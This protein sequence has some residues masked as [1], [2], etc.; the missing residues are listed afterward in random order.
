MTLTTVLVLASGTYA[1]RLAGP[2]LRDRLHLPERVERI[3]SHAA[4][5]LLAALVATAALT[6]D[7]GF[8]G[9]ARPLGV[10]VGA[11][12]AWRRLPFVA[13]VVLAASTTALL[14]LVGI[15]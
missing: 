11:L 5:A 6:A 1:L 14:R 9:W 15:P 13:V 4:T 8:S 2:L 7:G 12:A 10:A 3:M